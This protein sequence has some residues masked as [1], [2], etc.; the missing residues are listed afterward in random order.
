[1]ALALAAGLAACAGYAPTRDLQGA[2]KAR[3]LQVMGKPSL[4][5]PQPTGERL[6]YARGPQG[7]HTYFVDLDAQGRMVRWEQR[8]TDPIFNQITPGMPERDVVALIGP[9]FEVSTLS[10]QRGK[11]WSYRYDN[12]FCLWFQVELAQDGTVRSAGRQIRPDCDGQ[13]SYL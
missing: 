5:L 3:V 10:R 2:D 8:L 9:S 7:F 11:V 12:A 6:V 4:V 13:V 1:M